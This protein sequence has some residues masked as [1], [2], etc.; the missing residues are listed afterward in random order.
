MYGMGHKVKI[1]MKDTYNSQLTAS[2]VKLSSLCRDQ[3]L[4]QQIY[5]GAISPWYPSTETLPH[6]LAC[7]ITQAIV[8]LLSV[9]NLPE[10]HFQFTQTQ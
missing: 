9:L 8:H 5:I 1:C 6:A 4:A 3:G 10:A 7:G 2:A